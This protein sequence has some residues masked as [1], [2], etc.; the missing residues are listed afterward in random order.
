MA[1]AAA[2]VR[3]PAPPLAVSRWR[4]AAYRGSRSLSMARMGEAT[5]I[6]E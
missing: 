3:R 4:T 2:G 5:K 1:A 6:E